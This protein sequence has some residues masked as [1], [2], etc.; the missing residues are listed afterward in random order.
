MASIFI[1]LL[2][3][4]SAKK[5]GV[6]SHKD[7]PLITSLVINFT[8]P[9]FVILAIHGKPLNMDMAKAPFLFFAAEMVVMALAYLI[10]RAL[11]LDRRTTG[12]LMLV[13]AFG[14]TGFLG[15]PVVNAAFAGNVHAMPSAVLMDAFG[16]MVV[17]C[18]VGII[19]VENCT[20]SAFEWQSMLGFLKTPLLFG[21][22]LALVLRT[23]HIPD[24]V[25]S[26]LQYL[27]A[28]TVPLV[29]IAIGLNLS[30]YS[31]R[32]FPGALAAAV[33][34]KLA[35]LPALVILVM[36]LA[37]VKGTVYQVG[38]TLGAMPAAVVS[39]VIASRYGANG[40]FVAAAI[41]LGTL[42]SVVTIPIV[43]MIVH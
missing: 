41:A 18:T 15:Y 2:I 35:L 25:M 6:L 20:G 40:A 23:V 3:G 16:M 8:M 33:T 17:L 31:V 4:Y 1:L 36:H 29:M 32:Q 7:A 12:G 30:T 21:T 38:A 13:S 27:S 9:A 22:L 11:R 43:L 42:I 14:N 26:S 37:G 10:A 24:L 39:G 19:V 34:L 28:A 5:I